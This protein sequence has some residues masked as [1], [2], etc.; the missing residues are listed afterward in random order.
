M[1]LTDVDDKTINNSQKEGRTLR[2]FT[3]FYT[4]EFLKDTKALN[5]IHPTKFTKAT[6]YIHEMVEIIEKLLAKVWLIKAKMALF[7]LI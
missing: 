5:I 1:N 6:D 3:E 4:E 7:I 2:E